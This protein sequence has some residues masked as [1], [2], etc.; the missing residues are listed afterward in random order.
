MSICPPAALGRSQQGS[1]TAGLLCGKTAQSGW[2]SGSTTALYETQSTGTVQTAMSSSHPRVPCLPLN[3]I[4]P[5][6]LIQSLH[7][8]PK[9]LLHQELPKEHSYDAY[10]L[11]K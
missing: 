5:Y 9:S 8:F 1:L 4:H 3:L 2:P 7:A 11:E 10:T 6:V